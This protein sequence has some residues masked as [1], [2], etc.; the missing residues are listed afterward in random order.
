MADRVNN[1][2]QKGRGRRYWR[3][4]E[5]LAGTARFKEFLEREFPTQAS[6]WMEKVSGASRRGFLKLMGASL[7]LAGLA[8]CRR[9]PEDN[10]VPYARRP[11]NRM[12]GVPVHYATALEMCGVGMGVIA[13]SVDGRPIK[14]EG[15]PEHPLNRGA[16]DFY[17]QASVLDLYDPERSRTVLKGGEASSWEAFFA[18]APELLKGRVAVLSEASRSPSVARLRAPLIAAGVTWFEYE[19]VSHDNMRAGAKIAFGRPLR[20]VYDLSKADVVVAID[21]DLFQGHPESVKWSRDFAARRKLHTQADGEHEKAEMNRLWVIESNFTLSG[22]NADHRRA[23]RP[24]EIAAYVKMIAQGLGLEGFKQNWNVAGVDTAFVE[25]LVKDVKAVGQKAVFV[26]GPR[27]PAAVHAVVVAI[28][29]AIRATDTTIT[30]FEDM[31][32]PRPQNGSWTSHQ[33]QIGALTDRLNKKEF[34][35]LLII[36]GNPVLN[37][38]ADLKF[39]A[40]LANVKTSIHLSG[41]VDE[42]S[43]LCTWH[44]P[45]AHYLEAWGD[46][47]TVDGTVSIAQPLIEPMFNGK[48]T[49]ELLAGLCR[50]KLPAMQLVRETLG[51]NEWKWKQALYAGYASETS[52]T[53][54][55]P[56]E[57]DI[58]R[59]AEAFWKLPAATK[60]DIDVSL[61]AGN[62]FDG[63][64]AN[65]GWLAEMPEPM[66]R[67]TWDNAALINPKTA[68]ALG[69]VSDDVIAVTAPGGEVVKLPV[70]VQP[71]VAEGTIALAL[72]Y[73]RKVGS[74]ASAEGANVERNGYLFVT[75]AGGLVAAGVKVEKTDERYPLA[76]VQDHNVIDKVGKNRLHAIVPDLVLE[77]TLAEYREDPK[78]GAKKTT[79]LSMWNEFTYEG[80][81]WGMAIDLTTCTGCSACVIACQAE[82]NVPIVGKE[83][84]GNGREMQ[85]IRIDRYFNSGE[86]SDDMPQAVHQPV[87]CMHCEM[88]PCEEV[89]PVAATTHSAEGL[90]MMTYNRCIGT[91]YC[92]NNC[93]YKVRRFNFF[94]YN[95][96]STKDLYT[97]NLLR[98]EANE[99]RRMQK[100]PQVTVR[101]RGV[102]EKCT[103]C[104]QRIE[105]ARITAKNEGDRKIKDGEIVTACQQA[106]PT[107]AIVFGDLSDKNSAVAKLHQVARTYGLLDSELNTKPRT[108]YIAKIRN[109]VEGLDGK[110]YEREE[111]KG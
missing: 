14:V 42:T 76:T 105:T 51:G 53:P 1:S 2:D 108:R 88:A 55:T 83:Q 65:N 8:S 95:S 74:I 56:Q 58:K 111:K 109:P 44:L 104:V 59:V 101:S 32:D 21:I 102:M 94:D 99:L 96:G 4:L 85:W 9:W 67:L 33:E 5:E 12:D 63:R 16:T 70:L 86:G 15:N 26:A 73:G 50:L 87:M 97:P 22:S 45:R 49:I 37:A 92:S 13:T 23:V 61:Y 30:Y 107:G 68:A 35:T 62:F 7:A 39:A 110:L 28:N 19:P 60:G 20:P 25:A 106:C 54:A 47:Q 84:V 38:P 81:K 100:N 43:Q 10:L 82:N 24:S 6:D 41:Y 31:N 75:R 69:V 72:G 48:S 52:R 57:L 78:L 89:C 80:H 79:S 34:D 71:G 66:T 36:G 18:A 90:N 103:Y 29:Q 11:V 91:R 27:Q 98:E 46:V 17:T 64:F 93:P 77:G 40:A 3:S